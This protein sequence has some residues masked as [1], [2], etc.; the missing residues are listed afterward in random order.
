MDPLS[1]VA[2]LDDVREDRSA[3]LKRRHAKYIKN[4]RVPVWL[5]EQCKQHMPI[6]DAIFDACE[7]LIHRLRTGENVSKGIIFYGPPGRG[8]TTIAAHTL[9]EVFNRVEPERFARTDGLFT[10]TP[11]M[12]ITH[13]SFVQNEKNCW[14]PVEEKAIAAQDL[15]DRLHCEALRAVDNVQ[16]LVLDDV[17]KEHSGK[18]DFTQNVLHRLIRSRYDAAAPTIITTNL[19]PENFDSLYGDA[20]YSFIHQAFDL[21]KVGG[22]DRRRG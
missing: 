17:G 22:P 1:V 18:S 9:L 7:A 4:S 3:F 10:T 16:V 14:N 15:S 6:D 11:G 21:V 12:Y 2:S 19:A 5:L 20:T 13:A 8:K